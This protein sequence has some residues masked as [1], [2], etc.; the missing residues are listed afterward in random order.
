M[1]NFVS[2]PF[3]KELEI[4]DLLELDAEG[5]EDR[6][7]PDIDLDRELHRTFR[8]HSSLLFYIILDATNIFYPFITTNYNTITDHDPQA[9]P[10]PPARPVFKL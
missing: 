9:D 7:C 6:K 10:V 5:L 1:V 2:M 8:A 4:H 3:E